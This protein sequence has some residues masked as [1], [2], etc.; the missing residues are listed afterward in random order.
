[1][2]N[3]TTDALA[4]LSFLTNSSKWLKKSKKT[5]EITNFKAILIHDISF[6]R[7]NSKIILESILKYLYQQQKQTK[8]YEWWLKRS[9]ILQAN[10][11]KI[12][13]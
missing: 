9:K 12:K 2:I 10:V 8:N 11:L 3:P 6:N 7:T 4:F 1:M 5:F 13:E